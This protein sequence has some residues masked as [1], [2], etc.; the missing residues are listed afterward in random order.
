MHRLCL[1]CALSAC[2]QLAA[3]VCMYAPRV[4]WNSYR[5]GGVFR[6]RACVCR[7]FEGAL[8]SIAG[9]EKPSA[10]EI[11]PA[12]LGQREEKWCPD[13]RGAQSAAEEQRS[14]AEEEC[15]RSK[16]RTPRC[17][18]MSILGSPLCLTVSHTQSLRVSQTQ[19]SVVCGVSLSW[20]P[21]DQLRGPKG[22]AMVSMCARAIARRARGM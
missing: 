5:Q 15:T 2:C 17:A 4:S 1:V 10:R 13:A 19:F 6:G 18:H 11:L 22:C 14:R 3:C 7:G 8:Q 21:L 20:H 9:L 12:F 16:E